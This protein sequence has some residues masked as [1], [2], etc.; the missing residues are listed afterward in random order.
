MLSGV[1]YS[2]FYQR[3]NWNV[4]LGMGFSLRT[5]KASLAKFKSRMPPT[6]MQG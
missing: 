4:Y 6:S 5:L 2:K 1:N 3:F